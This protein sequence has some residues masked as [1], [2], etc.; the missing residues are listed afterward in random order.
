MIKNYGLSIN[1]VDI[2]FRSGKAPPVIFWGARQL[3]SLVLRLSVGG[4]RT[5][6]QK[7]PGSG[8]AG[9]IVAIG[10]DVTHWKP[11]A[12]VYGYSLSRGACTQ[13]MTVLPCILAKKPKNVG[14]QEAAAVP[15]GASPAIV[16][17]R[18]ITRPEKGQKIL[19]IGAS[20]GIGTYAVQI[21]RLYGAE[22]TGVCGPTNLEMDRRW[23]N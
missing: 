14:F 12:Q 18:D 20:G 17:F 13:Y 7:I 11:G 21:T 5:P 16:A 3:M 15:G 1:T 8:F 10:K 4:L 23:K 9:E 2:V 19:I 22:V 6:K